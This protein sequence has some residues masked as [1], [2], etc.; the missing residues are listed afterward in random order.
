MTRE[1][2][3]RPV[4]AVLGAGSWGT[5][6]AI[7][8]A[9]PQ[10]TGIVRLWDRTPLLIRSITAERENRRY[11]PGLQLSPDIIPVE[12]IAEALEGAACVVVA[13][14]SGAVRAVVTLAAPYLAPGCDLV[15]AS[16]GLEP[17]T[18]LLPY[19][20]AEAV[21]G[22]GVSLIALS[23]P[24]LAAEIANGVPAAAVAACPD[25][26][27]AERIAAL[28]HHSRFRVYTSDDRIGVEVGGA[29]KN[30]LAIAGGVSDGLGFGDNTKAA[31]LTRGLAE[32]ARFGAALGARRDTF[33][34]LAGV[35]DLMAT[36]ASRL[37]RNWRV[38][39][40]I[41]RGEPLPIILERLGQ[42]AE[43]VPT[44]PAVVRLAAEKGI[45]VPVCATVARLLAGDESPRDAVDALMTRSRDS[46]QEI[47]F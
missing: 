42:V 2:R 37:S 24:N 28:F 8:L 11:L 44:A 45:E 20:V 21:L 14:P 33:Y 40:G 38:G 30:V 31:L 6:L 10:S 26:A 22:T 27:A 3:E 46:R 23:G 35:G 16:K 4:A 12:A 13:V 18:G 32:M 25:L 1:M 43:G 29:V 39:E 17:E 47:T 7:L 15:L 36:A 9:Q 34:G 5:A 19:Q 41:A